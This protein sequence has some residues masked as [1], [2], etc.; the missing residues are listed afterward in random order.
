MT[1]CPTRP[2]PSVKIWKTDSLTIRL[3]DNGDEMLLKN[4]D[5]SKIT[6]SDDVTTESSEASHRW[7]APAWLVSRA[8][9]RSRSPAL[10]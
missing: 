7:E 4:G 2:T 8:L 1:N 10:A 5:D 6:I 3:D 9:A